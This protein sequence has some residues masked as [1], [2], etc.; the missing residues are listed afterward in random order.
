MSRTLT[1]GRL[2]LVS[3]LTLALSQL[4]FHSTPVA[5]NQKFGAGAEIEAALTGGDVASGT[6]QIANVTVNVAGATMA[7]PSGR[8]VSLADALGAPLPG[9]TAPGFV[10]TGVGAVV[11]PSLLGADGIDIL[12]D[13]AH[14]VIIGPLTQNDPGGPFQG[15]TISVMGLELVPVVDPRMDPFQAL[16]GPL[17]VDLATVPLGSLVEV[18]GWPGDDGRFYVTELGADVGV[19]AGGG[20][21]LIAIERG[22]CRTDKGRLEVRGA[23]SGTG[24][25]VEILN[26]NGQVIAT[27]AIDPLDG[28]FNVRSE[29]VLCPGTVRARHQPT[30]TM[31]DPFVLSLR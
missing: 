23:Y 2:G 7:L 28:T 10:G 5:A 20:V 16:V 26:E 9:R 17:P 18:L 29:G 22:Q 21:N 4:A 24:G 31:S 27:G 13:P 11:A 6:L 8:P 30:G 1:M 25:T 14:N 12:F 3:G 15:R 19:P